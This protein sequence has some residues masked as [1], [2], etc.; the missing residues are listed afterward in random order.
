MTRIHIV[1]LDVS[2]ART[3]WATARVEQGAAPALAHGVIPTPPVGGT[4]ADYYPLTLARVRRIVGRIVAAT[5]ADRE[6]GDPLIVAMEGPSLGSKREAAGQADA[7][8][9]LRWLTYHILEKEADAF[10]TIPPANVKQY[11]TGKGS[12]PDA[13]KAAM[14]AGIQRMFPDVWVTDDNEA[15]ALAIVAMVARQIHHELEPSVQ[16]CHPFALNAVH[17]PAWIRAL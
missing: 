12:G 14:V 8:A 13:D 17:W 4:A 2:L 15:D 11:V 10:V 5:R 9:G 1:G 7:R 6:D 3:G 16:R